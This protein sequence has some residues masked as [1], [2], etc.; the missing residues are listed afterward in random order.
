MSNNTLE[1]AQKIS[2]SSSA[3]TLSVSANLNDWCQFQL[4]SHSSLS[5]VLNRLSGD[6]NLK[7]I[8]D[9]AHSILSNSKIFAALNNQSAIGELV[10]TVINSGT[11][12]LRFST[13][14]ASARCNPNLSTVFDLKTNPTGQT[15]DSGNN[16]APINKNAAELAAPKVAGNSN[17]RDSGSGVV[18]IDD[19][20]YSKYNFT[21]YYNGK[22]S[23]A[24]YYSGWVY[25]RS[26]TYAVGSLV[27][28]NINPNETGSNGKYSITK[29]SQEGTVTDSGKVFVDR[30]YDI[31]N[32]QNVYTPYYFNQ[33]QASGT[34]FLGSEY[35]YA[36][37]LISPQTDFG[38]DNREFDAQPELFG[39]SFDIAQVSLTAAGSLTANF[40]IQ[41]TG[42]DAQPFRVAFY[43]SKDTT[44]TT[45]DRLLGISDL[46]A[47]AANTLT[48]TFSKTLSLPGY[49]DSFW[50]K[51]GTDSYYI[52]MIVDSLNAV[53]EPNESNNTNRGSSLD[54]DSVQINTVLPQSDLKGTFFDAD[55]SFVAGGSLTTSFQV[56]N[57]G[58][59]AAAAFRVGFY[60]S[61]D[62]TITPS[63]RAIGFYDFNALTQ[64][65]ATS[66]VSTALT[67]PGV[68]DAFWQG[69]RT[70]YVG[71][72]IDPLSA[73]A[74]SNES[75]NANQG[76]GIDFNEVFITSAIINPAVKYGAA[77]SNLAINALLDSNH[78]YWNTS[79]NGG[80]I[81]YSFYT[82]T[83]GAYTGRETVSEVSTAIKNNTRAI[84]SSIEPF[85]NVRFVEV[86]DTPTSSGVI[87]YMYSDGKTS[88]SDAAYSFYAYAYDPGS[89]TGGDV[90]LNPNRSASFEGSPGTYGYMELLHETLHTLGLKHPGNYNVAGGTTEAPFL[91]PAE[92]NTT[93]TVMTYNSGTSDTQYRGSK[94]ITPMS[95]DIRALQYLYGARSRNANA[96]T[97]TFNTVYGYGVAS[98]FFGSSTTELKQSIW[99][100]GGVDTLDFSGLSSGSYRFD[101]NPGGILTTQSS[102]NG[103]TYYDYGQDSKPTDGIPQGPQYVTSNFGT[104]IAYGTTI[105]NLI[106]SRG[107]DY[108]IANTASNVFKGY[109]F[110]T[111]TG[112]DV[113]DSSSAADTLELA[114]FNLSNLTTAVSGSNLTIGLGASGSIQLQNYYG[115]NGSMRLLVGGT[116]YTYSSLGSWVAAAP[117]MRLS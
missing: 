3:Q 97:Y 6:V 114:G 48:T 20:S 117:A 60:L 108:I 78:A 53:S 111:F 5:A 4:K 44:I 32:S 82:N 35:D 115:A 46:E 99:D 8:Q 102:F 18:T 23:T 110:G 34:N 52:G 50:V 21:Y 87:R 79:A 45:S 31:D 92:D 72:V 22:D 67:L 64:G 109:T 38:Q 65:T 10:S 36:N 76:I 42:A 83:S 12:D 9:R 55:K 95:Y 106:N 19:V 17:S 93:N 49:A 47:I 103:S 33:G 43:L 116:Y 56:Q 73:V 59:A 70:Y 105:E 77:S 37:R 69:N 75:N 90:H 94:A 39:A 85:I 29:S 86:A 96:T 16:S 63:D 1:I 71:M 89:N 25:A 51:G 80:V 100:S 62:S 81:T 68:G 113:I 54:W 91:S 107:N 11:Y 98:Q 40:K 58:I 13:S 15:Y 7:L 2:L 104:T 112:D 57:V 61:S 66:L 14:Q 41:N 28:S 24:D 84:L 74:E 27:D 26:G 30:Y 101:L 88:P